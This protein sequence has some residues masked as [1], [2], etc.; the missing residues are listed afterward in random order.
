MRPRVLA[1]TTLFIVSDLK[2]SLEFYC[3]KLG[4]REPAVWGDPPCFALMN[5]DL[6]DLMLSRAESPE[7]IRPNGAHGLW[8]LY[9]KVT[10]LA[11]E[12][13]SVEAVG[14]QVRYRPDKTEYGMIEFDLV[15]HD[16]YQIC[17]GQDV[18]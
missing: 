1:V 16:G 10:D 13:A 14:I 8:D 11:T 12:M 5:R 6:F 7:Q 17:F 18:E 4:F 2:R 3:G 15:D 9:I